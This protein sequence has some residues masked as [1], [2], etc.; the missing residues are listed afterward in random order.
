MRLICLL[1]VLMCACT[2]SE[3]HFGDEV[4]DRW[5]ARQKACDEDAFFAQWLLGTPDCRADVSDQVDDFR[6][7]NGD[8][9]CSY[10]AD[11]AK[12]CVALVEDAACDDLLASNFVDHCAQDVWDCISIVNPGAP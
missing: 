5:C 10:D 1:P 4:A 11:L 8:A 7:G 3:D 9:A 12:A 2:L 6:Y